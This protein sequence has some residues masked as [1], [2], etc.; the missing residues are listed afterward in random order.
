M[1]ASSP[2]RQPDPSPLEQPSSEHH[3]TPQIYTLEATGLLVIAA[4]IL[5]LTLVRY[6]HHIPWG[7]R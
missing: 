6:W 3:R 4:L 7:A 1:P 5:I 2:K